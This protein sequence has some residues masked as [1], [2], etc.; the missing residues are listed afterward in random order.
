MGYL[1]SAV[2]STL[3]YAEQAKIPDYVSMIRK[4]F[5]P[6]DSVVAQVESVLSTHGAPLVTKIDLK[7]DPI[8]DP[9]VDA[10]TEKY[11]MAKEKCTTVIEY[12]QTKKDGVVSYAQEK[13]DGVIMKVNAT[14]KTVLAAKE[15]IVRQVKTGEIE[16]T[17]LK[18]AE[19][20]PYTKWLAN[21]VIAYKG[22][23][24]LNAKTVSTQIK[25]ISGEQ[26]IAFKALANKMKGKLPIAEVKAKVEQ[27][28]DIVTAKSEP[29]V[30]MVTPYI[31]K[32]KAEF[33]DAKTK[34]YSKFMELKKTYLVKKAA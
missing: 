28:T 9:L 27:F 23:L 34:V 10:A 17:I 15:D 32:A 25:T 26:M 20:S 14:S 16:T 3:V 29:Y 4:N 11:G 33:L 6:A 8:V 30:A 12:A 13:K 19:Y 1:K 22:K 5:K 31:T 7:L 2:E 21:T 18:K 24:V